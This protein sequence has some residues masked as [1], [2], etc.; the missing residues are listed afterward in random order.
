[1]ES[2]TLT[3]VKTLTPLTHLTQ[4]TVDG[5]RI[6]AEAKRQ[7]LIFEPPARECFALCDQQKIERVIT[8]VVGNAI[9]YTHEEGV[10]TVSVAYDPE[11][12]NSVLISVADNGIGIPSDAIAKVTQR[13]FRIGDQPNGSGLGL[14][15]SRELVELHGGALTIASPPPRAEKGTY[16]AVRLLAAPPPTVLIATPDDAIRAT[17]QQMIGAS[18]YLT[19][20]AAAGREVLTR[21]AEQPPDLLLLDL[22][23][24]DVDGVEVVLQ[25]RNDKRTQR[26]PLLVLSRD[27]VAR[28]TID[29]LQRFSIPILAMPWRDGELLNRVAAAF[30][31]RGLLGKP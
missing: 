3:L 7:R 15:I 19:A 24:P 26:L 6:Q 5:L 16:V 28:P 9:K 13:Y 21:C 23:L 27:T 10:I 12:P 22:R 20:T 25:L 31:N 8:N 1:L 14:S 4:S 2:G 17:L 29:I 18:G 30:I 11:N